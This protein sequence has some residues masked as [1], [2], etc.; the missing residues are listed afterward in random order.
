MSRPRTLKRVGSLRD[1]DIAQVIYR[2]VSKKYRITGKSSVLPSVGFSEAPELHEAGPVL[3]SEPVEFF[4][5]HECVE[6]DIQKLSTLEM[7]RKSVVLAPYLDGDKPESY[8]RRKMQ[9]DKARVL[10]RSFAVAKFPSEIHIHCKKLAEDKREAYIQT[11]QTPGRVMHRASQDWF[12]SL[13]PEGILPFADL[14]VKDHLQRGNEEAVHQF[15]TYLVRKY[16]LAD[17]RHLKKK[18]STEI[19]TI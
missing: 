14:F 5:N 6:S 19:S 7:F 11:Q 17:D 18:S 3:N 13:T 10:Y 4:D 12:S 9:F 2:P 1:E 8:C 15:M 16:K